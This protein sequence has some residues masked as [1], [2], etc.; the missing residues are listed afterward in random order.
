MGRCGHAS[1]SRAREDHRVEQPPLGGAGAG[2][3]W[4][5]SESVLERADDIYQDDLPTLDLEPLASWL[6]TAL[7]RST[8][9]SEQREVYADALFDLQRLGEEFRF[10]TS[11]G[12]IYLLGLQE[13]IK[14]TKESASEVAGGVAVPTAALA[15]LSPYMRPNPSPERLITHPEQTIGGQRVLGGWWAA[16]LLDSAV[17]RGL[18]CLDRLVILLHCAAGAPLR[19][20]RQTRELRLPAFRKTYLEALAHAFDGREWE[21]LRRLLDHPI[22]KLV[23][24][25][26]DGFVHQRR[27]SMELHGE[28]PDATDLAAGRTRV[29]SP[30]NH[31]A[32]VLAFYDLVLA[33][34]CV[35]AGVLV[36]S[37]ETSN[38]P[39]LASRTNAGSKE[40]RASD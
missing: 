25:Y 21:E 15:L 18:A 31:L 37:L 14:A 38:P 40:D 19:R 33:P 30:D 26:R 16:Q 34:S 17:I 12:A 1:V 13:E 8:G 4:L 28:Y 35:L 36:Q 9:D 3:A 5:P 39:D 23:K 32:L 20:E 11:V 10:G 2:R 24:R 6:T 27:L 7:G 22:F 29:L